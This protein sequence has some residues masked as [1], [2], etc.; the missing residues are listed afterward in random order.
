MS[1][2]HCVVNHRHTS[3]NN[4]E[5]NWKKKKKKKQTN[6]F[7]IP[8]EFE[9]HIER[10]RQVKIGI[11]NKKEKRGKFNSSFRFKSNQ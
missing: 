6:F 9:P 2:V 5:M 7:L 3:G 8:N 1:C 10:D 4:S 11:Q